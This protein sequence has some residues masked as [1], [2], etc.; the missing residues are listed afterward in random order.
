VPSRSCPVYACCWPGAGPAEAC[1]RRRT[2]RGV[3]ARPAASPKDVIGYL[4]ANEIA[5]TCAQAVGAVRAGAT[6]TAGPG[7]GGSPRPGDNPHARKR[8]AGRLGLRAISACSGVW[9]LLLIGASAG[10]VN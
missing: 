3:D 6:R 2:R 9:R 4:R 8:V 1:R 10:R 5:L 7:A